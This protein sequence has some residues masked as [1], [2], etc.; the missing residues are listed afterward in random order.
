MR[1]SYDL[2][3]LCLVLP[4]TAA[5]AADDVE[6]TRYVPAVGKIVRVPCDEPSTGNDDPSHP[7]A[8]PVIQLTPAQ[9]DKTAPLRDQLRQLAEALRSAENDSAFRDS[10][11]T[12]LAMASVVQNT[13]NRRERKKLFDETIAMQAKLGERGRLVTAAMTKPVTESL[14]DSPI[15]QASTGA[16]LRDT[17]EGQAFI[18]VRDRFKITCAC[19]RQ[20]S[21]PK[22]VVC[23]DSC[24]LDAL[25]ERF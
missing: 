2:V 24:S 13:R 19:M 17:Q 3:F 10:Y 18:K 25:K 14:L 4:L 20:S 15:D 9:L 6:C 21:A 7:P 12:A 22:R 5:A 16:H 1:R 8:A 23:C 11:C